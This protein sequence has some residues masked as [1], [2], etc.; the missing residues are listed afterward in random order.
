ML[1]KKQKIQSGIAEVRDIVKPYSE[2]EH[3][4]LDSPFQRHS[5]DGAVD[6][7]S[8]IRSQH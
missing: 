8:Q 5:K 7:E 2:Q 1:D 6:E 3:S 4:A